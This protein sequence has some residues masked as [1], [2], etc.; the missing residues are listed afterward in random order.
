MNTNR[1]R[2]GAA[3]VALIFA[4]SMVLTVGCSTAPKENKEAKAPAAAPA[5]PTYKELMQSAEDAQKN[6]EPAEAYAFYDKAAKL[7]PSKK[8]PWLR[9]AQSH[10]DARNYGPAIMAAQEV[11]LRDNTD[12]TAKTIIAAS[13]L[14]VA[15]RAL[16]Q[17]R[18][19]NVAV[20][21]TLDEAR[22][23]SRTMRDVL[24]E[25]LLPNLPQEV[26]FATGQPVQKPERAWKPPAASPAARPAPAPRPAAADPRRNPF[27]MLKE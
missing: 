27:D 7:D 12:V 20:V 16:E 21:N 15:A 19:S 3:M 14:R 1:P 17:L 26:D 25:P 8:Q 18:A 11:Q 13:G 22:T 2:Q 24:G 4:A 10:F 5:P 23:L 6:G 9:M